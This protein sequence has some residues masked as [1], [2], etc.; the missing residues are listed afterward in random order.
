M[1]EDHVIVVGAGV[2]G[3][4]AAIDLARRGIGVTVVE[5]AAEAGGKIRHAMVNGKAIDAG[6]TVFTMRW[7]FERLF[8][9]AGANLGERI[10]LT[11]LERLAHHRWRD[12]PPLDLFADVEQAAASIESFS[13]AEDAAGYRKFCAESAA[14]FETLRDPFILGQRPNE[15]DVLRRVGPTNM[16]A[17]ARKIRP[18]QTLWAA[19]AEHFR[20]PHLR[21][22]FARY[23]TYVGSS[24]FLT[25][26][27][28]MLVA[29]VEQDGV[30][31]VRGGMKAVADAM[32]TLAEELGVH[33]RFRAPVSEIDLS[34]GRAS[35]IVLANGERLSAD[36][37]IFNGDRSALAMG[38]LKSRLGAPVSATPRKARSLSAITWCVDTPADGAP[39]ALHNVFFGAHYDR[40][41]DAIFRER[42][43]TADPTVYMCAQDRGPGGEVNGSERILLLVNG[44]PDGDH[45]PMGRDVVDALSDRVSSLLSD[46]GLSLTLS[47]EH[48]VVTT[49]TDFDRAFPGTGGALYGQSVHGVRSTM[50]RAGAKTPVEGLF[51]AGG[52]VH[53]GPGVPMATMSGRLAAD[54]AV[55][56]LRQRVTSTVPVRGLAGIQTFRPAS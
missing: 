28:I 48:T 35:G 20:S 45:A 10:A 43:V 42:T 14:M 15:W 56:A 7:I 46:C 19:L 34:G 26:A 53:P 52:S 11:P 24:P 25:P 36:A 13:G 38:L 32:R 5:Q 6:P 30:W 3:L 40:E 9:D 44:P 17:F 41:F 16:P 47:P 37:V 27:T 8:H 29:H 4:A 18:F 12:A 21:Q 39:L 23:A 33:F 55:E 31:A 2:G 22:L 1:T 50:A 51:L 54:A 49:P